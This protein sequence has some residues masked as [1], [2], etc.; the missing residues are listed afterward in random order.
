MTSRLIIYDT[1]N[2]TDFP[3]G[4]QITSITNF[5]LFLTKMHPHKCKKLILVGV[6]TVPEQLGIWQSVI[7]NGISIPMLPVAVADTDLS[8]T[9]KSLRLQYSK[10]LIKYGK[11]LKVSKND[12]CYIHTPEACGTIKL[13]NPLAKCVLFSHGSFFNMA[14]SF[15]FFQKNI[16]VKK[17]FTLYIKWI[18]RTARLIFV[19]DDDSYNA[20]Q[21]YNK[22]LVKVLNS[23]VCPDEKPFHALTGTVIFVGRLSKGKNIKPIIDAVNET[24]NLSLM[25]VGD[26]EEYDT[27]H[28][29]ATDRIRFTG[30]VAPAK[31]KEYMLQADILVMNSIFEGIPMTI[32]EALSLGIPVI[33]TPVGGIPSILRFGKDSEATDGSSAKIREMLQKIYASYSSYSEEAYQASKRYDYLAVNRVIYQHLSEFWKP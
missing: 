5:L 32:L 30:A 26:G 22:K 27:L 9:P 10:G 28:S 2:F 4:G 3:I 8:H 16:L 1:S 29:F 14:E 11:K 13:L 19:L 24:D 33:S 12:C 31:V 17:A 20:Y 25:I 6:T 15:R 23:I 21:K 18:I 7:I